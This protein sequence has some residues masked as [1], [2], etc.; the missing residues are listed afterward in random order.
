EF[1]EVA[2]KLEP[3]QLSEPFRSRFGWHILEVMDRRVYDNTEEMKERNCIERVRNSK[4]ADES[5]LWV[6]RIRDEAY[7]EK[8]VG[9]S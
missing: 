9:T 3:G 7:V 4:L 1:E 6:R 8:R 5:E 2:N